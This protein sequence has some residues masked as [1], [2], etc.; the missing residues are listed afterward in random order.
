MTATGYTGNPPGSGGGGGSTAWADITGKPTTFPPS[1]HNQASTTISDST[2]VGRAVLTAADA[3]AGR[4]AIG[5]EASGAASTAVAAHVAAGDPHTQYLTTAEGNAAYAAL[6]HTHAQSDITNLS[7]ALS[8]K[9]DLASPALTGNPTAPTQTAGNNSTR[10]ATTAYVAT[11]VA[12]VG[13][14]GGSTLAVRRAT[15]TSGNLVLTVNGAWAVVTGS[16]SMVL[17]A[18][19]GDYVQ[20]DLPSMLG[21]FA[22]NFADLAVIVG[23]TIV[24]CL[25]SGTATPATEGAPAFYG[26]NS[27]DRY[28][29]IFEFEV[30]AG[31]LSG[32]NVT[33]QFITKGSGGGTIYASS[34]YPLRWRAMNY[35][36]ADVA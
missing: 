28:G 12:A 7:T 3:A 26:D 16:P 21:N 19:V 35:G 2:T 14:G 1:A 4:T 5:A 27:F 29:P 8:A 11:A 17:P 6:G 22:V 23:G 32:G 36:Q 13:G 24:R 30:E 10:L 15:V 31:D 25:S 33:V 20:F 34:D 18:V 9:A